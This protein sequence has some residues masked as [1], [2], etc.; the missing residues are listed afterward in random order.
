MTRL[1][2]A[3]ALALPLAFTASPARACGGE[4][5]QTAK[6]EVKKVTVAE[7]AQKLEA[8]AAKKSQDVTFV[9]D[10]NNEKT[11]TE[12]GVIPGAITLTSSSEY[13]PA[14]DLPEGK[15]SSLVFYCSSEKCSASKTAAKRA[16]KAGYTDVAVLPAGI[17]GW[18]QAGKATD[19][20]AD[21]PR[22]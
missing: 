13:D 2:V 10:V 21:R 12:F 4:E 19:K 17:K 16:V 6:V 8:Q 1:L 7:L 3:C 18:A 14:K 5:G 15:D 22:T 9:V 20:P 11:R